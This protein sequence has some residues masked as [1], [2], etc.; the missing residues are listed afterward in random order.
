M[1]YCGSKAR[2]ADD[3]I[4][5][6]TRHLTNDKFYIE[7]F[8]GGCN[9]LDKVDHPFKI[10]NDN[11]KYVIEMW[12]KIQKGWIPPHEL[13]ESEYHN[14][15][16]LYQSKQSLDIDIMASIGY[17]GNA[18]SNGSS[19]FGG[20]AHFNPKKREN[21]IQEAFNG[22][23]R[24]INN[25]KFLEKT[26][27]TSKNYDEINYP[28]PDKCIIYC[29]PPYSDTK[30]YSKKFD[31]DRFWNWVLKMANNGY[32]IYISEY[33][34][35]Y[36]AKCIFSKEKCDG[37]KNYEPGEKQDKKIEKLFTINGNY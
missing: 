3:L 18:C 35:P 37:M 17:V 23:M 25:F 11:N 5:I 26:V 14:F 16:S 6:I 28:L 22:T 30:K 2:L 20:Y 8:C 1:R 12:K 9:L 33:H 13:T 19:W 31:S 32:E 34:A 7:P 24:Q 15:K 36:F 10:A 29:D 4:P 21:H 27:F